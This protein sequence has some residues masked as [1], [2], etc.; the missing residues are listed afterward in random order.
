MSPSTT[1]PIRL[2]NILAVL[3][4]QMPVRRFVR[5][6][7]ITRNAWGLLHHNAH[8]AAGSGKPKVVYNTKASAVKAADSMGRKHPEHIYRPYKCLFCD[9]YHIGRTT[10]PGQTR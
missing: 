8:I 10:P 3:R 9:G 6:V 5:N 2:R 7:F 1:P 4:D